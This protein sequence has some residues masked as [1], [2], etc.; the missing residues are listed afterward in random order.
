M[1]WSTHLHPSAEAAETG[2]AQDPA[3][4]QSS[5]L[6]A[7][8]RHSKGGSRFSEDDIWYFPLTST[9]SC[10]QAHTHIHTYEHMHTYILIKDNMEFM[11]LETPTICHYPK[12]ATVSSTGALQSLYILAYVLLFISFQD[13]LFSKCWSWYAGRTWWGWQALC[14]GCS[15]HLPIASYSKFMI[16]LGWD[17]WFSD[18]ISFSPA[19]FSVTQ[20]CLGFPYFYFLSSFYCTLLILFSVWPLGYLERKANCC[21]KPLWEQVK[22]NKFLFLGGVGLDLLTENTDHFCTLRGA[23]DQNNMGCTYYN[24]ELASLLGFYKNFH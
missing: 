4:C 22:G 5:L 17:T 23:R 16:P 13:F 12:Y 24:K 21:R 19:S 8:E 9:Y 3:A 18:S 15:W 10:I 1:S 11:H 20:K 14:S 7:I 6:Q 2:R